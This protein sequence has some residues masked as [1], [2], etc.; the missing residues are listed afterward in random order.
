MIGG[1]SN[2]H[3]PSEIS[4]RRRVWLWIG[5]WGVAAIATVGASPGLLFGAWIFPLGM[6]GFM[7]D[8]WQSPVGPTTLLIIGWLPYVVLTIIGLSQNRRARYF[9]IFGI[10]CAL[11]A[12]NLAGCHVEQKQP[13]DL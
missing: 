2:T 1:I 4:L 3:Q 13:M 9:A 5:A 7:P 11:L 10:L 6:V 8:N 12:F